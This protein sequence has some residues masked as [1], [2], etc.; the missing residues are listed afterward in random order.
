[1]RFLQNLVVTV[2]LSTPLVAVAQTSPLYLNSGG[3]TDGAP[4]ITFVVQNGAII[5]QWN[6]TDT[7]GTAPAIQSTIKDLGQSSGS[8]GNQYSLTGDI[9]SGIYPNN[10]GAGCWD[11][12]TDGTNN[13]SIA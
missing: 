1:M 11:G 7:D 8:T 9:L 6:R 12:A 5:R 13:W 4:R 3:E 2:A 10:F